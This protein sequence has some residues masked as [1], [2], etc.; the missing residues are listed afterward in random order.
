MN[1]VCS[2]QFSQAGSFI[3]H[4]ADVWV[5]HVVVGTCGN[6][7]Q[8]WQLWWGQ[9]LH[10]HVHHMSLESQSWSSNNVSFNT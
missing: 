9:A 8:Y 3:Q 5:L 2:L 1:T 7:L 6:A 4:T 10:N